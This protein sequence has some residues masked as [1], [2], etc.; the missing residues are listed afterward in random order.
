LGETS[1]DDVD[2]SGTHQTV[3]AFADQLQSSPA[4]AGPHTE[5]PIEV[6]F[7]LMFSP[8][9]SMFNL[10]SLFR[11]WL[12]RQLRSKMSFW[13]IPSRISATKHSC[14]SL[15]SLNHHWLKIQLPRLK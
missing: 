13:M 15:K 9:L 8:I 12:K 5:D 3:D 2:Q 11:V 7:L 6:G 10:L 1:V 4:R 14:R